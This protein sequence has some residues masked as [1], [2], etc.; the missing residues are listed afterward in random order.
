MVTDHD[1]GDLVVECVGRL[2]VEG[3]CLRLQNL[4]S[5]TKSNEFRVVAAHHFSFL[6][7]FY[8]IVQGGLVVRALV[9]HHHH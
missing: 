2:R 6:I 8:Q 5:H 3:L 1:A 4:I 9:V 7:K